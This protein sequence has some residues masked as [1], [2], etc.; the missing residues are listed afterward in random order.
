MNGGGVTTE[1]KSN[2]AHNNFPYNACIADGCMLKKLMKIMKSVHANV[3]V[4][5]VEFLDSTISKY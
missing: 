2:N 3:I 1:N 5:I 4:K